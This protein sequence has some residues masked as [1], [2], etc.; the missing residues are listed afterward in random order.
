VKLQVIV[1]L[2]SAAAVL[3]VTAIQPSAAAT[4]LMPSGSSTVTKPPDCGAVAA[5]AQASTLLRV[6]NVVIVNVTNVYRRGAS[7]PVRAVNVF[8]TDGKAST[9]VEWRKANNSGSGSAT[10]NSYSATIGT[11]SAIWLALTFR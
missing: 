6:G 8:V 7:A 1:P 9:L 5:E 2:A 3:I 10:S 4:K 11:G